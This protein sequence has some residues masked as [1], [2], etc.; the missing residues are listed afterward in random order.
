MRKSTNDANEMIEIDLQ[1]LFMRWLEKWWIIAF[2][3][4][5]FAC[6]SLFYTVNFITPLYK[7]N[8]TAYVNN[9]RAGNQIES[10]SSSSLST[11]KALVQTYIR[12]ISSD[13]VLEMVAEAAEVDYTAND[14][15]GMLSAEQVG[16]T[17]LFKVYV[18]HADPEMTV[19][20]ANAIAEVI[21]T[22]ISE[23]VEGS[24]TKIIDYA[25]VPNHRYTPS[26]TRNTVLGGI[27]GG[28]LS[29]AAITIFFLLDVRIKEAEDLMQ[30][31]YPILGQIPNFEQVSTKRSHKSGYGYGYETASVTEK[32]GKKEG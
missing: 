1:K 13:T 12:I 5:F 7:A 9:V 19:R 31:D 26:Y 14:I 15:R 24:S 23:I 10:I 28:V 4:I 27:V 21:P 3:G 22:A 32:T 16:E 29:V 17:E 20:I 11:S 8:I 25:K 18:S 2:C 30:Y 6:V